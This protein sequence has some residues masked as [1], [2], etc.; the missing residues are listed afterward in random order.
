MSTSEGTGTRSTYRGDGTDVS[1]WVPGLAIFAAVL[2][3]VN[4]VFEA[5]AGLAALFDNEIY[6]AGP[7][8]IY[9][10]DVTTW[11][12]V[13]LLLG[14]LIVVA[15]VGVLSG[16]LWARIVGI[17]LVAASMIANFLF[18]PY[19]PFWTLLVIALDVFVIW[20]LC[21]YSREAA[22]S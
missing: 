2:M 5:L 10:F 9:S 11:G 1:P 13:H 15:G 17:G 8:Y 19:Y 6:V 12:W 3:I 14:I 7:R 16:R 21:V 20:A 4:G 18:L 22:R